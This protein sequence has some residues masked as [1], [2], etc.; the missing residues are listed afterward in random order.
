MA[1]I[2]PLFFIFLSYPLSVDQTIMVQTVC[3]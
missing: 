3:I 2:D 1:E